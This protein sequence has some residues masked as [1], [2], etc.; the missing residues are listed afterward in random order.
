MA[1]E[2]VDVLIIGAGASAAA[3][4]WSMADTRMKILCLEQGDWVNPSDYPATRMDWESSGLGGNPNVRKNPGDY[5]INSDDSPISIINYNGVGGG[6][7]L[8]AGHFPR[9]HPSDFR[10][11]KL[12][13]VG[14]DW[15]VDYDLLDPFYNE[16]DR[17]MGV[18]G[19]EGDPAYPPKKPQ[20]P[21]I[22]MGR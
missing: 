11:R 18:A 1:E 16:N 17:M 3:F 8:F 10:V 7:I 12:D 4:A 6:T 21:P 20:M 14:E 15:P 22:P 2:K 5:P 9:F 13:G 19:L